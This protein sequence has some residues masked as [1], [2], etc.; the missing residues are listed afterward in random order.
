MKYCPNCGAEVEKDSN[1]CTSCGNKIGYLSQKTQNVA[2]QQ[3]TNAQ[4]SSGGNFVDIFVKGSLDTIKVST[5]NVF[6]INGF[7]VDWHDDFSGK[8]TKGSA[9]LNFALGAAAQHYE[10]DFQIYSAPENKIGVRLIRSNI[11]LLGGAYG[12]HKVGKQ[13]RQIVDILSNY[14]YQQGIY[15]GRNP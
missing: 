3:N 1:F 6:S 10:I 9:G 2:Q 4:Q 14:F 15:M 8:A 5:Q 13:Y 12:A 7:K 11:G